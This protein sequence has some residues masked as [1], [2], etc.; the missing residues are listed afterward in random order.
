[1]WRCVTLSQWATENPTI[2]PFANCENISALGGA[3]MYWDE[4]RY[5][6]DNR[7]LYNPDRFVAAVERLFTY[8]RYKYQRLLATTTANYDMFENYK[9]QKAGSEITTYNE[10]KTKTGTDTR[11]L[12][13]QD[14]RTDNLTENKTDT[15]RVEV[16]QTN[17]PTLKT[18]ETVTPTVKEEEVVTP[19]VKTKEIATPGVSTTTTV[20]PEGFTDEI[21]RTTFDS[22]TYNAVEKTVHSAGLQGSTT[23]TPTGSDTKTTEVLSGNTTTVKEQKSGNII[24][25][26]EYVSGTD[27]TVTSKTGTDT[28]VKTNTGTETTAKT[29]T[30][31]LGH[32][33]TDAHTGTE[34]LGFNDRVDSG[35]MY[36]EPQNAITDERRIALFTILN[37]ILGDVEAATL[38][39]VY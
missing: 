13:L 26:N 11:T 21:S 23:V 1:M 2:N 8:N 14:Q 33:T 37:I 16:T 24:T 27:T 9:L 7:D 35:H 20:T 25:E 30:D 29:G 15:P 22:S 5:R 18:K 34:S 28:S 38:L 3:Q 10:N 36:R 31:T 39:S 6:Y 4:L 19:T 32:N 12:N 17:T